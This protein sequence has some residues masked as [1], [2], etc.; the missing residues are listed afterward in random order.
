[1]KL[2]IRNYLA[3]L[4]LTTAVLNSGCGASASEIKQR[5]KDAPNE[6][7]IL[8]N[9]ILNEYRDRGLPIALADED[10]LVVAS[11]FIALNTE[12]R[13]RYISRIIPAPNGI[14]V[15]VT[16]E[17]QRLDRT[18]QQ[19]IWMLADDEISK[20]LATKDERELAIAIRDRYGEDT[21]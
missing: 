4:I 5:Q 21:K 15:N 20:H 14:A 8:Y 16:V 7:E 12:V 9:S 6:V 2:M 17:I 3:C 13:R 18:G 10:R 1:M 11:E 19:P